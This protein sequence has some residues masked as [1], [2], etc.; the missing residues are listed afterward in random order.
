MTDAQDAQDAVVTVAGG[1][2]Q[3]VERDGVTS[4]LG[5]P[6]AAPPLGPRRFRLPVPVEPWDGVRPA[7]RSAGAALQGGSFGGSTRALG[8][9]VGED[10]L[11]LNVHAPS[12][13]RA[14]GRPRPVL[15]WLH[16]GAF[17]GGSGALYQGGPLAEQG[18]LVVVT[19]NYRLG[20]FG[21]VDLAS[22]VDAEV[23]SLLGLRDQVAALRWVQENV[24]AFGGDPAQVVVA[25]ESAGSIS[26]ALLLSAPST[27]GLFRGA[28][29]QSGSYSLIHGDE[30][31]QE[32]ARAYARNL[33]LGRGDGERLWQLTPQELLTAQQAVDAQFPGTLPAA[34]WFDGDLV[35]TS[36]EEARRATRPEV[37][38]LAGHNRDEVSLF[39]TMPGDIMPTSRRALV[40]RLQAVLGWADAQRLLQHYP[41][42]AAGTRALGT[43]LNFA[44]PTRH[45]AERHAGA[46]GPTW[47]YRFDATVPLL[48]ATHAAELPYLWDWQGATALLLRGRRTPQR[49]AL[50]GRMRRRW[51]A[52]AR[53]LDPG[54]DWPAFTLPERTTLVLDPAGDHVEDDPDADR[55]QAWAGRDVMPRP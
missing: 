24:A 2:L 16:G 3:G 4:W 41:D 44:F 47:C 20:V 19:V 46:G 1:Q 10:C 48:G 35:P 26:V 13:A 25:G 42:S 52:F 5:V 15:V 49:Q 36:L 31:R 22:A 27:A 32:V 37:A 21:F 34:P 14:D 45:F 40:A 39:Q 55:R 28:V 29:M 33:G 12:A 9:A 54:P 30:A 18:D 7:T 8:S 6:Y 38:L 17:T 23:P 51:L 11:Y 43:D 50:A 53:D